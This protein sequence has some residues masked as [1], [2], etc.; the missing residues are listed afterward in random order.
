MRWLYVVRFL[1]RP[2]RS[3]SQAQEEVDDELDF[4]V[5]MEVQK[6]IRQGMN[7]QEAHRRAMLAFG[8]V[9]RFKEE[10][11][12]VDGIGLVERILTDLR[13]GLRVLRKNPVFTLVAVFTLALGIGGSTSI[14]SVVDGIMLRSLPFPESERLVTVWT[15]ASRSGGPVREWLGYPNFRDLQRLDHVFEDVAVYTD[16]APTLT[17]HGE[18]QALS[19]SVVSFPMLSGVLQVE[20]ATGR[21][22]TADDDRPGAPSV[23]LLSH[24]FWSRQFGQDPTLVGSSISLD[25]EPYTV[26]GVMPQDFRQPFAENADFWTPL[27]WNDADHPGGRGSAIV[28][29]LGR[30]APGV[31]IE[32][33]RAETTALGERLEQSFPES[34]T[35]LGYALFPLQSDLVLEARSALW[36]LLGSVGMVLLLVCVNLANLLL[37]R[38]TGRRAEL[39]VRAALG[40][41]RKRLVGQLLTE[42]LLL[43][44]IGGALGVGLAF[45]G[46]DLLVSMAPAGVPRLHEVSVNG[47]V[48][49]FALGIT[50]LAGVLFGLVPSLKA[51]K[52][53]LRDSLTEGGRG[54]G[55]GRSGRSLRQWLVAGQVSLAVV[56]LVGAG[57]LLRSFSEL[58]AVDLGF[59]PDGVVTMDVSL[60]DTRYNDLDAARAFIDD[61][62]L[63]L[64]NIPGIE[65]VGTTGTL[66][67]GGRNGDA[68]FNIEGHPIPQPGQENA[69]WIRRVSPA[70]FDAMGLQI[71]RGRGFE[72][73]DRADNGLVVVVNET[74]ATRYFGEDD[75]I[76]RRINV[77]N[78]IEP[79]WRTIVGVAHDVRNFGIRGNPLN[80]M[81]FP[82]HQLGTR[83][84]TVVARTSGDPAA[85]I[86][87]IR[88]EVGSMDPSLALSVV[89]M[90]SVVDGALAQDRFVTQLLL[91][92]A[93][94]ALALAAVGLYGVVSYDIGRRMHEMGVRVAL[95]AGRADIGRLVVGKSLGM[96]AVGIALGTAASIALTR[97]LAGLLFGVSPTDPLT[98][99]AVVGTL[100]AVAIVASALP[101]LKAARVDPATILK[102]D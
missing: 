60:P 10:V 31:T 29:S 75:P 76:G 87:T 61:L 85:V 51:S 13:Y 53:E 35:G 78:P 95:G 17:G 20:P 38:G 89:P 2:F 73:S 94:I 72:D 22:F 62:E 19:G 1:L 52:T 80:A 42:S 102:I 86:P 57:L 67:L 93:L 34:N 24:G 100:A 9:D 12:E 81:Y 90:H 28:Q 46:T 63:R 37:A 44:A 77:N 82:I 3:L 36:I 71:N 6:Y 40:A 45:I 15:D 84:V 54:G 27:R 69:V 74:L 99:S 79:R 88:S 8:G 39:A 7:P 68:S 26:L 23:L 11:R 97:V 41:G 92:F 96:A 4:H 43:A 25:G 5:E 50:M 64:A 55:E 59:D 98:F 33:A 58:R 21:G 47:R 16:Y 56:L 66:P 32:T 65:S 49:A 101:A 30:L 83:F 14:F 48:I 70:Y 18:A 91:L